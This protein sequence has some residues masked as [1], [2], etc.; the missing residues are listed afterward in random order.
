MNPTPTTRAAAVVGRFQ[1]ACLHE[2]H[3]HLIDTARARADVL[4]IVIGC[5]P[6]CPDDRNPMDFA[7]RKAMMKAAYPE[8]LVVGAWDNASNKVWSDQLDHLL[9]TTVPG[10]EIT[11]YGSRDSFLSCYEGNLATLTVPPIP[12]VSGT[13]LRAQ[14]EAPQPTEDF[15]AGVIYAATRQFYP[16][17][18]Q[19]VDVIIQNEDGTAVLL[20]R[21]P[22]SHQWC[23]PGGFVD[24]MDP[25]LEAA[26]RREA[27]EEAGDIEIEEVQYLCS[28]RINDCR[29][30]RS[31]HKI[32]TAVFMAKY[33]FGRVQAGDDLAEVRWEPHHTLMNSLQAAH[34]PIA[35]CFLN[36]LRAPRS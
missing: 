2:G 18:F 35:N 17:S 34:H 14:E 28:I 7:T 8:A 12:S 3:R 15:R 21:K 13:E 11:L 1:V 10:A 27:R 16:T 4:V 30:R 25:S 6:A 36:H 23:F 32:L 24:P 20:G 26:A 29:Y 22:G 31:S 19:T 33:L 5:S 9:K